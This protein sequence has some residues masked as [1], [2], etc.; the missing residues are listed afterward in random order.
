M[1]VPYQV[2]KNIASKASSICM[3]CFALLYRGCRHEFSFHK[4]ISNVQDILSPRILQIAALKTAPT[5]VKINGLSYIEFATEGRNTTLVQVNSKL[6]AKLNNSE[7]KVKLNTMEQLELA[8]GLS[9]NQV[10]KVAQELRLNVALEPN[11]KQHLDKLGKKSKTFSQIRDN[12][13][14]N[15][16]KTWSKYLVKEKSIRH[17]IKILFEQ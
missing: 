16:C 13:S 4:A 2:Q 7:R 9:N 5:E 15:F 10:I 14:Q 6:K 17:T 3:R 12:Q 8:A 1:F 11:L